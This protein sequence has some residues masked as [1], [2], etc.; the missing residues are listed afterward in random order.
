MMFLMNDVVL[1]FDERGAPPLSPARFHALSLKAVL[2]LGAELYAE[3]PLLQHSDPDKAKRLAMLIQS[4]APDV[5]AA[6]FVAA[7]QN[8]P[9]E[10]VASRVANL[11]IEVMAGLYHQQNIGLLTAVSADREVW[12]RL[13]A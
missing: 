7:A 8:C 2:R 12:R 5:N 1:N 4:K 13:A 6:L 10:Q 11:S 9:P 3:E